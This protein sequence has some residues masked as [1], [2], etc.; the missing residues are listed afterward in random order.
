[1]EQNRKLRNKP[2]ITWS[3]NLPQR[4]NEGTMGKKTVSSKQMVLENWIATFKTMKLDYFLTPYT[5]N[6]LKM[7]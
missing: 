7:D 5:K 1:M 6:K 3:I 2:T 4:R